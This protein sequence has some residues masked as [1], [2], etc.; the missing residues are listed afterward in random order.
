MGGSHVPVATAVMDTLFS[1][2]TCFT[3]NKK[4][5]VL[6]EK[7]KICELNQLHCVIVSHWLLY[8]SM[9]QFSFSDLERKC[10]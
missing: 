2:G 6:V 9:G 1:P 8:L 5:R 7:F 4:I 10:A 3:E